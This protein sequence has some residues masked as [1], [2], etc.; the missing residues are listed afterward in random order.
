VLA[1]ALPAA[2]LRR[3]LGDGAGAPAWWPQAEELQRADPLLGALIVA[4]LHFDLAVRLRPAQALLHPT[5]DALL[6]L[7][8]LFPEL[9]A[10]A[11]RPAAPRGV[12]PAPAPAPAPAEGGAAGGAAPRVAEDV[13]A[14]VAASAAAPGSLATGSP[15]GAGAA[16]AAAARWPPDSKQRKRPRAG[17]LAPSPAANERGGSDDDG[18]TDTRPATD[19]RAG[20][21]PTAWRRRI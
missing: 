12:R 1:G 16:G 13:A 19:R 7:P 10:E 4:L 2:T 6:P 15:H 9:A 17:E 11:L 20:A 8:A 18:S 14:A 21:A 3:L 5:F